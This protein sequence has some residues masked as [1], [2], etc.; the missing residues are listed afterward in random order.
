M[1]QQG[2]PF[3]TQTIFAQP[4]Q[5]KGGNALGIIG[6]VFSLLGLLASCCTCI[7][8]VLGLVSLLGLV[9]SFVAVFRRPKGMAITGIILGAI[10]LILTLVG[11]L[12]WLGASTMG[13]FMQVIEVAV[14]AKAVEAYRSSH[15][16][17]P[18]SLSTLS[19]EVPPQFE[20]D[21]WNNPYVYEVSGDGQSFTIRSMGPDGMD[22]TSDDVKF[23]HQYI[24]VPGFVSEPIPQALPGPVEGGAGPGPA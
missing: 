21:N 10:G 2:S 6:F 18:A 4:E 19:G 24:N 17:Y 12:V 3:A 14:D 15:G 9:L 13:G 7:F 20:T 1:S 16:A 8:P 11:G 5:P 22:N 23:D